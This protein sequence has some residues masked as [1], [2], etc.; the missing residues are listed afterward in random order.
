MSARPIEGSAG[1]ASL[2][3]TVEAGERDSTGRPAGDHILSKS[4]MELSRDPLLALDL[5]FN[6]E[7]ANDAFLA[8]LGLDAAEVVGSSI[9]A[10]DGG[11]W[12]SAILRDLLERTLPETGAVNGVRLDIDGT[13]GRRSLLVSARF[14]EHLDTILLS[15]EDVTER[16]RIEGRLA[17]SE[18]RYR[19]MFDSIDEGFCVIRMLWDPEGRPVD[20]RFVEI[21]A[22]FE[23]QTGLS[24]AI[25]KRMKALA[26]DHES[27]WFEIYG[28]VARTGDPTRF[29]APAAAIG[30]YYEV[31]AFK[32]ARG[33]NDLV[34][35]LFNDVTERKRAEEEKTLLA[36][37]LSHRVK[38]TLA[39]VQSL[40]MQMSE[41]STSLEQYRDAFVGRIRSMARA[42][43]LLTAASWRNA[44]IRH[45][46]QKS[47]AAVDAQDRDL[48][49]V[50]GP[51]VIVS[52]RQGLGLNLI[53]HELGTNATKHGALGNGAGR[54]RVSW[55][56]VDT[57]N[58]QEV[59]LDWVETDGPPVTPPLKRGFGTGLIELT[60]SF[61]LGGKAEIKYLR[62]GLV[63]SVVFPLQLKGDS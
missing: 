17:E 3:L 23:R 1:D 14:H 9:Y 60:G 61:E 20:Y 40:A 15:F 44:D 43:D 50:E 37:E 39:V 32:P 53:L 62:A 63:C 46:V 27:H 8:G 57:E 35:V 56:V 25:G 18:L 7:F 34:A 2:L 12:D 4:L 41:T 47:I 19:E 54:L 11:A 38:N 58:G 30:H 6:V 48:I 5:R 52:P 51:S 26:P 29:E 31:Y 36:R 28:K 10:L 22:A 16:G 55:Q 21:N 42:H 59:R 13:A 33:D 49:D 45:V 24:D